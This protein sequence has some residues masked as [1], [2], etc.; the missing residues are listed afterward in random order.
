MFAFAFPATDALIELP[1]PALVTGKQE[2]YLWVWFAFNLVVTKMIKSNGFTKNQ[3]ETEM[4]DLI[5]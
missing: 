1:S 3:K 4:L 5:I 2:D